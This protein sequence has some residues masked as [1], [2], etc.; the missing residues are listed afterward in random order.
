MFT[1]MTAL[2]ANR[3][4]SQ[5]LIWTASAPSRAL[6]DPDICSTSPDGTLPD[7]SVSGLE[8]V[9]ISIEPFS[10]QTKTE[11]VRPHRDIM[12]QTS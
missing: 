3:N 5:P 12:A 7:L 9:Q 1:K 6:A 4:A 11:R 2:F 8:L 10:S